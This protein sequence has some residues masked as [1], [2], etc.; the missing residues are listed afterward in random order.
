MD[1]GG[2]LVVVSIAHACP[3]W[4][5]ALLA[6][7]KGDKRMGRDKGPPLFCPFRCVDISSDIADGRG[8][9]RLLTIKCASCRLLSYS[10][11]KKSNGN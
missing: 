6:N 10:I 8:R 3:R 1:H 11:L 2:H 9:R 5:R 4:L 7:K